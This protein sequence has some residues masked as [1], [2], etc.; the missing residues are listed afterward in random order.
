VSAWITCLITWFGLSFLTSGRAI[1]FR[2]VSVPH[3]ESVSGSGGHEF[4]GTPRRDAMRM[5]PNRREVKTPFE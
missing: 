3:N 1:A 4:F 5:I 2:L